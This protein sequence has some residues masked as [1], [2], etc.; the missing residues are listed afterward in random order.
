MKLYVYKVKDDRSFDSWDDVDFEKDCEV[1]AIAEG[2]SNRECEQKVV[3][4]GYGDTD[5][6]GWTYTDDIPVADDCKVI[7]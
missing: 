7:E 2:E 3:D 5:T 1:V 6:Y 4:A